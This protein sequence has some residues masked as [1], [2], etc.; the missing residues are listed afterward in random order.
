M[1]D[2]CKRESLR[3]RDRDK[4]STHQT[5]T[6]LPSIDHSIASCKMCRSNEVWPLRPV[7]KGRQNKNQ[8]DP[9]TPHTHNAGDASLALVLTLL[10]DNPLFNCAAGSTL[11]G[12]L[13][14]SGALCSSFVSFSCIH[15]GLEAAPL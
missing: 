7:N 6:A 2:Q 11:S 10:L 15:A 9:H 4:E 14:C 12:F 8:D 1:P 3:E 5:P 13:I